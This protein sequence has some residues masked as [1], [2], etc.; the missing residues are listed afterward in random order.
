[1][2]KYLLS[3]A[4]DMALALGPIAVAQPLVNLGLVGVGRLP[5][6]SFDAL[7]PNVD[8]LGGFFSG[9]WLDP[10]TIVHSNG[11]IHV[12][13]Y[14][15]PDRGFGDGLQDFSPASA[16]PGRDNYAVLRPRP[17]GPEPDH[18]RQHSNA[19]TSRPY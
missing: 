10:A 5:A 13:I 7:G 11:S 4:G 1:M 6:D 2:N 18:H 3:C 8:T 15:L 14:G 17:S 19:S 9:M 16:A 12:T